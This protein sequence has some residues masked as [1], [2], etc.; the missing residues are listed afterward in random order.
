MLM[1]LPRAKREGAGAK[2]RLFSHFV[3]FLDSEKMRKRRKTCAGIAPFQRVTP[4]SG[5][6]KLNRPKSG[7]SFGQAR[8]LPS[9]LLLVHGRPA[10]RGQRVE[11]H[12]PDFCRHGPFRSESVVLKTKMILPSFGGGK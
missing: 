6:K 4:E 11:R 1:D 9:D 2:S 8:S 3:A 7:S 12:P 10:M 5:K